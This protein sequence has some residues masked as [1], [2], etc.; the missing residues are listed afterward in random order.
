[1]LIVVLSLVLTV[2]TVSARGVSFRNLLQ[3]TQIIL[4]EDDIDTEL[5]AIGPEPEP[6]A[7]APEDEFEEKICSGSRVYFLTA[8]FNWTAARHPINYPENASWS[9]L[10][11]VVHN[12]LYEMFSVG[13]NASAAIEQI[14][15]TG[16]GGLLRE[17]V[18]DC[19]EEGNCREFLKF[20]CEEEGGDCRMEGN[21]TVNTSFPFVSM[22]SMAMPSPD[23]FTGFAGLELCNDGSWLPNLDLKLN[24]LD[25][26][27][28]AGG[29]FTAENQ[30]VPE[31]ERA[32]ITAFD[33]LNATNP[34]YHPTLIPVTFTEEGEEVVDEEA[35]PG[36]L[37]EV[38]D[39]LIEQDTETVDLDVS[40]TGGAVGTSEVDLE[41]LTEEEREELE[42]EEA[43]IRMIRPRSGGSTLAYCGGVLLTAVATALST[44]AVL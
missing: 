33:Q 5:D 28:D 8:K 25:A 2:G 19:I 24:A 16:K 43:N 17:E 27:T 44:L 35:E 12:E 20:D 14:A 21:F 26:G 15:E 38:V 42:K 1:M 4:P 9:P 37:E 32:N 18:E 7:P 36:G 34:F 39:I 6:E 40:G 23:W 41:D 30:D 22:M 11:G 3:E 13:S 31:A 29:N 10:Y